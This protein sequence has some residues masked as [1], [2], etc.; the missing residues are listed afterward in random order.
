MIRDGRCRCR[1]DQYPVRSRVISNEAAFENLLCRNPESAWLYV[2]CSSAPESAKF[3]FELAN[4][5]A[6]LESANFELSNDK[7]LPWFSQY[8]PTGPS[9]MT[10]LKRQKLISSTQARGYNTQFLLYP[11]SLTSEYRVTETRNRISSERIP[12]KKTLNLESSSEDKDEAQDESAS[13]PC[14]RIGRLSYRRRSE[15]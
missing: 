5:V 9:L 6:V 7:K 14:R 1:V 11:R 12:R 15:S 13:V 8:F 2:S 4:E 3:K 10:H